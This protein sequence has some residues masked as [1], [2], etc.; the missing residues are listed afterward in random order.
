[1]IPG[2]TPREDQIISVRIDHRGDSEIGQTGS[3]LVIQKNVATLEIS[4]HDALTVGVLQR[5]DQR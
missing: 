1:M 3:A 4:V 2:A 5:L